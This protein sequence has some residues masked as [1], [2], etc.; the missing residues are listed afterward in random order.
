[1]AGIPREQLPD[2]RRAVDILGPLLP[3]PAGELGIRAG[4][5]VITG[6]P[7]V[8][9]AAVGSGAVE[10]FRAHLYLGTS[11]WLT[12][13]VPF[14]KT[15]LFHNMAS[16]PSALPGKYLVANE[17]ETAGG[18]LGF[19]LDLLS[20]GRADG[21]VQAHGPDAYA[22]LERAAEGAP[23]GSGGVVFTP[24]LYG[25]RTPVE[26]HTLRGGF[27][28]LSLETRREHLI[29]SVFEGVAYNGRWLLQHVE[30]FVRRRFVDIHMVGG[31]A[32]SDLWCRI[33]ADV[34]GRR[35]HQ[36]RDPILANARGAGLLGAVAL[37]LLKVDEIP[38]RV[39]I[40]ATYEP[41]PNRRRTY[42]RLFRAYINLYRGTRGVYASMHRVRQ[43]T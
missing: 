1:M 27:H 21:A 32:R 15:D 36:V 7:D 16:L 13:H 8:H 42:D 26:E 17:Q 34:L 10:D 25:E 18:C 33:H 35:I 2:L 37:G 38:S 40:A 5:P 29:R 43:R 28:N 11:S 30:R 41:D 14:K 39:E 9:S 6:T 22:E 24:W 3:G 23:A 12:C 4:T 31:G 20:A 19:L